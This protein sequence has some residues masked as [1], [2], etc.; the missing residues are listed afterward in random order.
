MGID[1][2]YTLTCQLLLL[3]LMLV[4]SAAEASRCS[5]F[6]SQTRLIQSCQEKCKGDGQFGKSGPMGSCIRQKCTAEVTKCL[7][8]MVECKVGEACPGLVNGHK[9][10]TNGRCDTI[11][12]NLCAVSQNPKCKSKK[13]LGFHATPPPTAAPIWRVIPHTRAHIG[14]PDDANVDAIIG[15]EAVSQ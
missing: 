11:V 13:V 8:M 9:E 15:E 14:I 12:G 4:A 10:S 5:S 7:G 2:P 1:A 6:D 3:A